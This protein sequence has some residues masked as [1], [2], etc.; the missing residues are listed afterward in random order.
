MA[1]NKITI[2]EEDESLPPPVDKKKSIV[3]YINKYKKDNPNAVKI[4]IASD[5]D[6]EY[7]FIKPPIVPLSRL[8]A[9]DTKTEGGFPLGKFSIIAGPEKSGKTTIMLQTIAHDML[10]YPDAYYAWIDTEHSIDIAYATKL[11]IDMS[12]L[13]V[14]GEGIMEDVLDRVIELS[15]LGVIRCVV[16][17]SVGGL[18]PRQE[19]F[20]SKGNEQ[21]L[22]ATHM[23]D[24]QRKMGQFFRMINPFVAKANCGVVLIT[25]VY[26]DPSAQGAYRV[27]GGNALKHW[28]H[29]RLM[30][31][32]MN[33]Q[34]SKDTVLMPD[35]EKRETFIG[36]DVMVKLDKTRQNSKE[37]Q[38][39][40]IP[41]R[42]GIGLD[43]F[44]SA[45][46]VA[47]N[48]G[49]VSRAG[50]WYTFK[51]DRFQGR[52]KVVAF[53]RENPNKYQELLTTIGK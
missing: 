31:S 38:S 9:P 39:V 15:K 30:V 20:D 46:N 44:E 40:V 34:D 28:G 23:L 35:G 49:I 47:I 27:K 2:P 18:T 7:G 51:E 52:D 25:H 14:I 43:A 33:D 22:A 32:R 6:L 42:Y 50:A 24:L 53:F 41:Y 4:G 45:I 36:H 3:D 48:T 1:K 26:Q 21:S 13:V 16:V 5:M 37:G 11:G 19:V 12:R 17:D 8:L 10:S 29:V